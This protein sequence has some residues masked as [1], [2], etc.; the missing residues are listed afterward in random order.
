[1]AY[2]LG[3]RLDWSRLL[4][5][6]GCSDLLDLLGSAGE[7]RTGLAQLHAPQ[8]RRAAL[9]RHGDYS[10]SHRDHSCLRSVPRFCHPWATTAPY[11]LTGACLSFL[12]KYAFR[13]PIFEKNVR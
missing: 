8:I 13:L 3:P 2:R 6:Q 1:M 4:A 5:A 11:S 7:S 9:L 12:R 10:S